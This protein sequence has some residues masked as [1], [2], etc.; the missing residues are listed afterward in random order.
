[1]KKP[2]KTFNQFEVV[3]VPF[4]FT[5]TKEIK[6]RPAL[7]LSSARHFN[8]KIGKCIMAMITTEKIGAAKWPLDI[9]I[10]DLNCAGLNSPSIIRLKLFTLER[11]LVL[12]QIGK[13]GENDQNSVKKILLQVFDL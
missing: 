10:S 5:D 7:I 1:M 12:K 6:R 8:A 9:P 3:V 2:I 11:E 4:P 13:L